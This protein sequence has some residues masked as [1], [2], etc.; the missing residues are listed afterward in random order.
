MP[1]MLRLIK[2]WY[3]SFNLSEYFVANFFIN[4]HCHLPKT[5]LMIYQLFPPLQSPTIMMNWIV[6]SALTLSMLLMLLLGGTTI[7]EAV[8]FILPSITW[9]WIT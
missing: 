7:Q 3:T 4:P 2:L 8:Q 6:I 5:S 9:H 1:Q